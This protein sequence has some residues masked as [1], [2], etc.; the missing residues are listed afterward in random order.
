MPTGSGPLVRSSRS[1]P[2]GERKLC[3][4]LASCLLERAN[5]LRKIRLK[6][7]YRFANL[8]VIGLGRP[9]R[10]ESAG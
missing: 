7:K 6:P 1:L 4:Q 3:A 2:L 8:S 5:L 10:Y 9:V